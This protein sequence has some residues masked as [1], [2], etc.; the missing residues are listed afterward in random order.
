MRLQN[1]SYTTQ[2]SAFCSCDRKL[3]NFHRKQEAFTVTRH[4]KLCSFHRH[5]AVY[6]ESRQHTQEADSF[7]IERPAFPETCA[8]LPSARVPSPTRTNSS[9]ATKLLVNAGCVVFLHSRITWFWRINYSH[10]ANLPP[11]GGVRDSPKRIGLI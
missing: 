9:S 2:L 4:R 1:E 5:Q 8:Q 7:Q 6:T 10:I 11:T 3:C